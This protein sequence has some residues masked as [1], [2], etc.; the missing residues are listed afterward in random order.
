MDPQ[1]IP[2][3]LAEAANDE[4]QTIFCWPQFTEL[5]PKIIRMVSMFYNWGK[6][7]ELWQSF[8]DDSLK[9]IWNYILRIFGVKSIL[10]KV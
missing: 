3:A 5:P 6:T 4:H 9:L 7:G 8:R 2:E 1:Y 10:T